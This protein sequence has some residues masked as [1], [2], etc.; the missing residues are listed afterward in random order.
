MSDIAVQIENLS[1][2]YQLGK[3]GTGSLRRD[4]QRWWTTEVRKKTDPY[5][6]LESTP[7]NNQN[8][9]A[10]QN[11]SFEVKQGEV[12][13][14]V[15][16]N[17]AGKST[18][19]KIVSRIVRP[20]HG[21][22][23]GRG[24]I[25]SLLEVGTGFQAQLTGRENI[26]LSGY[27]LGMSK[28]EVRMRFDEIVAFSGIEKFLDTPV[29][30]Y[31]S[32]MYVRLAFAVAAHLEPDILVL[33]E[34]LA[35]G[36]ADFQKKCLGKMR[37]VSQNTGRTILFVSHSMQAV[38]NLCTK[39]IW[40]EH[41]KVKAIG[42][43]SKVVN[44][45]LADTQQ[46]NLHQSWPTPASAPGND[47]IRF[48]K[49][50]LVPQLAAPDA[51]LDIRTPFTVQFE[52]WHMTEEAL[53][54]TNLVLFSNGGECI[55]DVPSAAVV[56]QKGVVAGECTIPGNFLNDGAYYISLFVVKDTTTSLY[57]YENCLSFELEDY[58]GEIKWYG[59]WWGAVRPLLPFR[60]TQA[61]TAIY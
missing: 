29:K 42:E 50:A 10:L 15:G 21:V 59:K 39:G 12:W 13:G 14:L 46:S 36:D 30:R 11:V 28:A 24:R 19:L 27:I 9:W 38:T 57:D 51:P 20:T 5:F 56:C 4:M 55:F 3:I 2:R 8:L 37:E 47:L 33:D 53:L 22:V 44:Q 25:S 49:V 61:E 23:R 40:L 18:L 43:A 31:S 54:S 34:V 41:G 6:Q 58:R 60:L 1:K 7:A 32:G 45:Y 35:V 48:K 17:G 26:F 52:F 16:N